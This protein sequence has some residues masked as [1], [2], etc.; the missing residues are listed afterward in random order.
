MGAEAYRP[1]DF[2][3]AIIVE[4]TLSR[5]GANSYKLKDSTGKKTVANTFSEL[6]LILEQ[7]NIQINNPCAILMQDTSRQFLTKSNPKDMYKVSGHS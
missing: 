2:G 5:E 7:F 3:K 4:R 6:S 1:K